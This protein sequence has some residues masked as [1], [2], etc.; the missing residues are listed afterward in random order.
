MAKLAEAF[1]AFTKIITTYQKGQLFKVN[2]AITYK[3]NSRCQMCNIWKRYIKSP[4]K[5]EEELELEEIRQT[6]E[7]IG[8]LV[9]VSLTGGEPFLRDDIV[10]IVQSAKDNCKVNMVNITTNGFKSKL[11]ESRVR[12]IAEVNVPLTFVN[13]SLDGHAELHDYMRGTKGAYENAIRTLKLLHMLCSKYNNLLIGF[14]YTTTPFNAG[15]LAQLVYKLKEAGCDWLVEN[16]TITT[17]HQGNL[18]DNVDLNLSRQFDY[19]SLKSK[20]RKD[21]NES[22]NLTHI[23]SPLALIRRTYLKYARKYVRDGS[24][25][26]RCL[27][28]RNSLFFDPYGNVFPCVILGH[29]IGNLRNCQYEVYKLLDSK[30]A[31]KAKHEVE[32]CKKCWT[33]CEAYPSIMTQLTSLI[34]A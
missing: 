1:K 16:L 26:L 6:F 17:Y 23:K 10:D 28:L 21:I 3:C 31:L 8:K 19:D 2:F 7:R 18:Y 33:P 4:E 27:A 13:I 29:K 24:A 15:N 32:I 12:D 9:W 14:E 20:M 25:P 22:L 5:A 34:K 30:Y 11:I